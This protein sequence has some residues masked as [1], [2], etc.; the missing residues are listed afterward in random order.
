M[1][2]QHNQLVFFISPLDLSY[3]I[4]SF[5]VIIIKLI[6]DLYLYFTGL[7]VFFDNSVN[8]VVMFSSQN[9]LRKRPRVIGEPG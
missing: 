6:P 4:V 7:L 2:P 9:D 3:N 8:A 5:K 1:A